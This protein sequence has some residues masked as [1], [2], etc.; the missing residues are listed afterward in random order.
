MRGSIK[1]QA[2][3]I[4][5]KSTA[6]QIG[7][8]RHES[9]E[10][11][12]K[13]FADSG[14]SAKSE[15]LGKE[16]GLHSFEY[17][18]DVKAILMRVAFFAR[19]NFGVRDMEELSG[20]HYQ[21]F[22]ENLIEKGNI[23]LDT[24][25]IYMSQMA[26]CENLLNGFAEATGSGRVYEIRPAIDEMR[27]LAKVSLQKTTAHTRSYQNPS[28]LVESIDNPL[29][30]LGAEVQYSSGFRFYEMGKIDR[31]QLLG[32]KKDPYTGKE[33][34]VIRLDPHDTKGGKGR[35]GY[36]SLEGYSRLSEHIDAHGGFKIDSYKGYLAS[37]E[38][39]A[40]LTAQEAQASHGL[41][42]NFAQERYYELTTQGLCHE[43]ALHA[44]SWQMGHERGNITL[45]YLGQ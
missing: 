21:M 42:W 38:K 13:R 17:T 14:M 4:I 39:A 16:V 32:V 44:V 3:Q 2:A 28:R 31:D 43:E 30:R 45:H 41:R 24:F 5:Q 7:K 22:A 29:H 1:W 9:K 20:F 34:G 12:K 19:E 8:S 33:K 10:S 18:R 40:H 25:R 11:A 6:V 35:E 27:A 23:S 26:K 15:N 36:M 37:L